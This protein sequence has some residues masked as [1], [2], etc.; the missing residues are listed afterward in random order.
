MSSLASRRAAFGLVAVV[1]PFLALGA[2][3]KD[4]TGGR[5]SDPITVK[6]LDLK[7]KTGD[8]SR[9]DRVPDLPLVRVTRHQ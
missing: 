6:I 8:S 3:Q 1:L 9:C 2:A 7:V 5:K 4:K